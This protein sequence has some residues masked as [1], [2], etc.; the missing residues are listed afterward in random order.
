[1]I[2]VLLFDFANLFIYNDNIVFRGEISVDIRDYHI[3][4][5]G[6]K[7]LAVVKVPGVI[8]FFGEFADVYKGMAIAAA[9]ND[10]I[11]ISV[12]KRV[13]NIVKVFGAST[14][15]KKQFN[16]LGI[17]AKP[18]E[19]LLNSIKAVVYYFKDRGIG[20]S[21][22][23]I[24]IYGHSDVMYHRLRSTSVVVGLVCAINEIFNLGMDKRQIAEVAYVAPKNFCG[25]ICSLIDIVTVLNAQKEKV[26]CFDM[27]AK[28][29]DYAAVEENDGWTCLIVKPNTGSYEIGQEIYSAFGRFSKTYP[30]FLA[31]SSRGFE[32]M[33]ENDIDSM[34]NS[35]SKD[36]FG[37]IKYMYLE[38]KAA[39][40]AIKAL[41]AGD[42]F[43][44]GNM[45]DKMG[46]LISNSTDMFSPELDWL[47]KRAK[48][49]PENECFGSGI[50]TNGVETLGMIDLKNNAVDKYLAKVAEYEHIFGFRADI[51][52]YVPADGLSLTTD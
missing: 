1:M 52:P 20:L 8:R 14:K 6:T 42:N 36:T 19:N 21:G 4:E 27:K 33:T 51:S 24:G 22:L 7:P 43:L 39:C 40:C 35:F 47:L 37:E 26:L 46:K 25:L 34:R 17:K 13:D 28:S 12:S 23:N 15:V 2:A 41:K 10:D 18:E 31:C 32:S 50:V 38:Y 45:L 9:D 3:E 11:F 5:Y 49:M 44:V 30:E 16:L 48:E 29:F